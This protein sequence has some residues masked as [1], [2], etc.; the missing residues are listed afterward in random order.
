[1]L[2]ISDDRLTKIIF[3]WDYQKKTNKWSSQIRKIFEQSDH[4]FLL[5]EKCGTDSY[6]ERMV[7]QYKAKLL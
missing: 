2:D 3:N 1:M 6:L 4:K 7:D 5:K